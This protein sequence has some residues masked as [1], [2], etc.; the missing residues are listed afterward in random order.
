MLLLI[1]ILS[2]TITKPV[3]SYLGVSVCLSI[4]HNAQHLL[5]RGADTDETLHSCSI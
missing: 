1:R 3:L 2:G 5:N 4:F